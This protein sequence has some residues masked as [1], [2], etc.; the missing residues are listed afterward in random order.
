MFS[1][2]VGAGFQCFDSLQDRL[3][4]LYAIVIF[5]WFLLCGLVAWINLLSYLL[6]VL[7]DLTGKGKLFLNNLL[8]EKWVVRSFFSKHL[9][10][11]NYLRLFNLVLLL[12]LTLPPLG[13]VEL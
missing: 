3:L 6:K 4:Q 5:D 12:L 9:H 13:C 1:I 11:V 7:A 2:V 10:Q 8:L